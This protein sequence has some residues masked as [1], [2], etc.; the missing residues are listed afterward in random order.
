MSVDCSP[1]DGAVLAGYDDAL[2]SNSA[3]TVRDCQGRILPF[4]VAR[5]T[6][7]ADAADE[8]LLARCDGPTL[9]IGCGPGRL[10]A[11]L[12]RRGL[13]ALG[14]DIAGTAVALT[15]AGGGMALRRSV[16]DRVPGAGRWRFALLADGNIGI[17]GDAAGL[18]ARVRELLAPGGTAL[19]EVDPDGRT[20]TLT[21]TV[22]FPDGRT[23]AT[24]PWLRIGAA[25]LAEVGIGLGLHE[26]DTWSSSGRAFVALQKVAS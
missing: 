23:P 6:R 8:S 2:W 7:A 9:D 24:F 14:V 3:M 12:G 10:V 5:W 17:G 11:A 13:P 15:R 22:Q 21:A 26:T 19:I 16:F 20:Q 25:A 4:D 1:W 18:L